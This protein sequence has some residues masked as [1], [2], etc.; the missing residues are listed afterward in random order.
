MYL[1]LI[2]RDRL[3]KK[4]GPF[5]R[6]AGNDSVI[7]QLICHKHIMFHSIITPSL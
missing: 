1:N 6:G 4:P 3:Q 2:N 7:T 5:E